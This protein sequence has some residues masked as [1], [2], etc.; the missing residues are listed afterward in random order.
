MFY[1]VTALSAAVFLAGIYTI[2]PDK[3][4]PEENR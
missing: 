2:D 1:L 3:L 4:D